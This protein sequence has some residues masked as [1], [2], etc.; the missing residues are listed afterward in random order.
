MLVA[1]EMMCESGKFLWNANHLTRHP[2]SRTLPRVQPGDGPGHCRC[3]AVMI[4]S[5]LACQLRIVVGQGSVAA[6]L[7]DSKK[8]ETHHR[9]PEMAS[10]RST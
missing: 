2:N 5:A 4:R 8:P 10:T 3:S 6:C 9:G 1:M 7:P